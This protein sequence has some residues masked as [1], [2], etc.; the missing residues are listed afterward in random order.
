[1][2]APVESLVDPAPSPWRRRARFALGVLGVAGLVSLGGT[3][4]AWTRWQ[5]AAD[6][7]AKAAADAQTAA[8]QRTFAPVMGA[9]AQGSGAQSYDIDKTVR[10]M[11]EIDH[12]LDE[13]SVEAYL[14]D[15]SREDYRG[16][17]P[18]VLESRKR[19]LELQFQ[20]YAKQTD[21]KDRQASWDLTRTLLQTASVVSVSGHVGPTAPDGGF[22]VDRQQ[23]Q[24]L[25][26]GME[27]DRAEERQLSGDVQALR[28]RLFQAMYEYSSVYWDHMDEWDR[29][30]GTRDRAYLAAKN[31]DWETTR[32]A[33]DQAIAMAPDE[34]E[35]HLLRAQALIEGGNPED[36]D[37]ART[38][39]QDYMKSHPDE[40]A[41]ALLLMGVLQEREGDHAQALLSFQQS[42]AYYPKQADKLTDM[43]D[44]YKQRTYLR[45]SREG[46]YIIEQY[47]SMMLGAG[48]YSP[49]LQMAKAAF[50]A[51]DFYG[52]KQKVMDHF[53]RRR[54]QQQWAFI[55]QD[56]DF[57]HGLLGPR[58][59]EIFPEDSYLD[60]DVSP[61]MMGGGLNVG[62]VNRSD[63]ALHNA[64]LILAVHFT[65]MHPADYEPFAAPKTMPAVLAH[66]TTAFGTI[67][68]H[69]ELFGQHKD[70]SDIVE[71]RAVLLTDEAVLWV[72]SEP[73]K[74]AEAKEFRA[75]RVASQPLP[76][77]KQEWHQDM[78]TQLARTAEDLRSKSDVTVTPRYG[79]ADDLSIELPAGLSVFKPVFTLRYAG[80]EFQAKT[81]EIDGDK[82]KLT[83]AGVGNFDDNKRPATDL[84]LVMN[85]VFGDFEVTWEPDG[86]M[87]WKF[88]GASPE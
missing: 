49:D 51:G 18:E 28:E 20:I 52:G 12:A 10:V 71:Q 38:T 88:E 73:Y 23:A 59:R 29:L 78:T 6:Q 24:D 72:D 70:V 81:N 26:R 44:P 31:A 74:I 7:A 85:S 22:S 43:L 14:A 8:A 37:L 21:L 19:I 53:A 64:T 34:K 57:A 58:F 56:I 35:A 77:Q 79:F 87:N 16:V 68:V 33:A 5:E 50:D 13:Q 45:K 83:F 65:D 82:I 42:A 54:S 15:L 55:L 30:C 46:G 76:E 39:L 41:P 27:A 25:L 4:Y 86:P 17:A 32:A 61:A 40:T 48:Y 9:L 2:T 62:V 63:R 1:M 67:D 84:V 36:L 80:Q 60:L 75:A 66:E 47:Q 69:T 11:H 3:W